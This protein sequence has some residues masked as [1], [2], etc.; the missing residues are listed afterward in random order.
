[1]LPGP[2]DR[3][4][5]GRFLTEHGSAGVRPAPLGALPRPLR[6]HRSVPEPSAPEQA[7]R[8]GAGSRPW[9]RE[10]RCHTPSPSAS[11]WGPWTTSQTAPYLLLCPPLDTE[12]VIA[13]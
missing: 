6:A 12:M 9:K 11:A 1:M 7:L 10:S 8:K 13:T 3:S 5:S 4:A 2:P